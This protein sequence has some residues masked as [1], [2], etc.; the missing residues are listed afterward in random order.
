MAKEKDSDLT[1]NPVIAQLRP[2]PQPLDQR[3]YVVLTGFIGEVT[4]DQIKVY[5]ELDLRTYYTIDRKGLA[6][7][8]PAEP[9][10]A[11]GP[12]KL[13]VDATTKVVL[14]Q[15]SVRNTE[16]QFLAGAIATSNLGTV[17]PGPTLVSPVPT[18]TGHHVIEPCVLAP[19]P[20]SVCGGSPCFS[21]DAK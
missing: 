20:P 4:A 11:S 7:W 17:K 12:T 16:A 5:P 15:V 9:G 14:T 2:Q 13:V 21:L 1:V 19:H 6:F 18:T 10:L 3:H 8:E